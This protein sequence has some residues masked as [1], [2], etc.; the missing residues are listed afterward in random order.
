MTLWAIVPS[1]PLT[2]GKSRLAEIL[3]PD[4][5]RALNE[6][7]FRQTLTTAAAIA[8]RSRTLAIS[9]SEA[10]LDAARSM[11]C[12]ALLEQAPY[13]LNAALD[14]AANMA[15]TLGATIILSVSCDL[16]FLMPDDLQALLQAA[17]EG[18]A[19]ARDRSGQGTNAL[20]VS[21]VGA[22]PYCYG[23]DSFRA[24]Q[25]AALAAGR[26]IGVVERTGLSFDIDTPDDFEQMKELR[27]QDRY[28]MAVAL[29]E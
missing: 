29:S 26:R 4:E 16:P 18:L 23:P 1:R 10:V 13:G 3:T 21:P 6:G 14:Q 28:S 7:F 22:I 17:E 5:R 12:G 24:H 25:A 11:A 15:R 20:V 27:G 19:I 9:R 2:E 8:G